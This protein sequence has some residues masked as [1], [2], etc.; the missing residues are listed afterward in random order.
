MR[1][2][3]T[4]KGDI[5][6]VDDQ[7]NNL[8]ILTS[9]LERHGY[10][11]RPALSGQL[12]LKAVRKSLPDIILLDILMPDMDGFEVC[13]QLKADERTRDIPII[14]IS[15]LEDISNKLKAFAAGGV[16]YITKPFQEEEV[17]IRA[18]THLK[19][20]RM[21][22]S[23]IEKNTRLQKEISERKK[24]E[25]A[26]RESEE[27]YSKLFYSNPLWLAV[28]ALDDG[29]YIEVNAAFTEIT[30]YERDEAIGRTSKDLGLWPDSEER[31]R[32]VK[33]AQEQGGFQKQEVTFIKKNGE[34]MS[35]LW[36]AETI[37][38]MGSAYLINAI[39]DVTEIKKAEE[40]LR[41]SEE[42]Y[43][44]FV[45]GTDDLV[46]RVD[47]EGRLI[48]AN[49]MA[50]KIFG[51]SMD[52][53][54][55]M[56]SFDFTHS[57]DKERTESAFT[58]WIRDQ[59]RSVTFENRQVNQTTGDVR[60]MLWTINLHYDE[61]WEITG[62]NSVGRDLTNY[63]KMEGEILKAKKLES[64]GVLA[65]GI[66]HDFNNLLTSVVGYISLAR[67]DMKPGS[68][69]FQNLVKA[70]KVSIQ[71]KE[72]TARLITFSEGGGPVKEIVSTGNL[73]KDSV[74]SSLKGSD[75]NAR[76]SIPDDISPV[77]VDEDQMKQ[78]IRNIIINAQEA[79]AG[80]GTINVSCESVDIGEKDTPIR[81]PLHLT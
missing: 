66:A 5:L 19:L 80:Q 11:A 61:N 3:N 9:I 68:K 74:D 16:D 54:I 81:W 51:V 36:S 46:T 18:E 34:L 52:N 26:L 31:V 32:L 57:D 53:C 70:E 30:G 43:R 27:K 71:T 45:E 55:G 56:S 79:M 28:S 25:K 63:K 76:F 2:T 29:H 50:E 12:A 48:Y 75:I 62:I 49:H 15:A 64:V 14:F 1:N 8:K 77:E 44:E 59:K 13:K 39:A 24:I 7:S 23:L 4:N 58:G 33:L 73:I 21:E 17:L 78:A 35:A 65:G 40:A 69:A 10:E 47:F 37:E 22:L 20:R 60:H 38:I 67:I 42:K 41:E 6:I 72:L